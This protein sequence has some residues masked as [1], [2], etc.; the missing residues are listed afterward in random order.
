MDDNEKCFRVWWDEQGGVVRTDWLEGAVCGIDD[1]R[2][3]NAEI[4]AMDRGK[5]LSLVNLKQVD[6]IDRPAREFFMNQSGSYRAVALVAGSAAT[7]MLA[8]F[9]LG[10]KRGDIPVKMFT[11]DADALAWL[12]AQP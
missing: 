9:F 11:A 1:A 5:V 12:Q 4:E 10:L 6:S 3:V 2:A 7:R 8:N